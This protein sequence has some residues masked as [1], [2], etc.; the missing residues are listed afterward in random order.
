MVMAGQILPAIFMHQ[1]AGIF[2]QIGKRPGPRRMA[3]TKNG[4]QVTVGV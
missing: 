1:E 2:I 3:F 4:V